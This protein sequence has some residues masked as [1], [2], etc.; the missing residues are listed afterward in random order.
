MPSS[1]GGVASQRYVAV[2]SRRSCSSGSMRR[3]QPSQSSAANCTSTPPGSMRTWRARPSVSATCMAATARAREERACA[4]A[5]DERPRVQLPVGRVQLGHAQASFSGREKMRHQVVES[6]VG[7]HVADE[8]PRVVHG[9]MQLV[10][11][12]LQPQDAS[13]EVAHDVVDQPV[14]AGR[15]GGPSCLRSDSRS[16]T[17]SGR[18]RDRSLSASGMSSPPSRAA[19][20]RPRRAP[21]PSAR[22]R[23]SRWE[24]HSPRAPVDGRMA[25]FLPFPL[26]LRAAVISTLHRAR[27]C[28][29]LVPTYTRSNFWRSRKKAVLWTTFA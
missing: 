14:D 10:L 7:L 28:G 11:P 13:V 18:P 16:G 20:G 25:P 2:S 17:R 29:S 26:V 24:C 27:C 4:R 1:P 12:I 8:L 5:V 22:G 15:P 19:S 3:T 6:A 23:R 9:G 21:G